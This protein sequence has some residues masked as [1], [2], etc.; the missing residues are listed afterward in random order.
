M[1]LLFSDFVECFNMTNNKTTKPQ[2]Y[3]YLLI[4]YSSSYVSWPA[5]FGWKPIPSEARVTRDEV[6]GL[7][8]IKGELSGRQYHTICSHAFG[9]LAMFKINHG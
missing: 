1:V 9:S 4:F 8:I 6:S 3:F 7:P 5:R 2:N